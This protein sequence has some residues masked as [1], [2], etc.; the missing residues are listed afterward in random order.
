MATAPLERR[1]RNVIL[2]VGDGMGISTVTA[3]RILDGQR[4]GTTG[5][6]NLLAF[7]RL[8]YVALSRTYSIDGQVPDSASTMTA[9]ITG[10]KNNDGV[11]SLDARVALGDFR[12]APGRE[13][14]TLVERAEARGLATGIVTTA[15]LTHATPAACYAHA[16][17]RDWESDADLPE[18]A[19]AAG[20]KDIARQFVEFAHG[21]GIDVALGGGRAKFL[22]AGAADPEDTGKSGGRGDGRDL[23]AAWRARHPE[24]VFVWNKAQFDAVDPARTR[25]LLG[26]FER[27]HMEFEHDRAQDAGGEPSL[28]EMTA[29][30]IDILARNRKGYVLVV[31]GGRIDHAHH[32]GNAYRALT[33]TIALADAVAAALGKVDLRD[34]LVVVTADHSHVFTIGGY[35]KRG[36]AILGKV[37]EIGA[38]G[39][40]RDAQGLPYTTLLYANGPGYR[41]SR[42]PDLTAVDTADPD[43]LQEAAV[44]LE[45]ET[46]AGEDVAVYAGGPMAHLVRGVLEQNAIYHVMAYALGLDE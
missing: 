14:A 42:R 41:G 15:R 29:K 24:G 30:A 20:V 44:P 23:V 8:P 45:S 13:L 10:A 12:A 18:A 3:A 17:H 1:A 9:L 38:P 43:Y 11:L 22:P 7:E 28:A 37:V 34:T 19:R 5:E 4:R 32:A 27:S 33:D 35:P 26:L 39:Y 16:A 40:A 25:R 6:E 2:F 46:H 21:D 36:N 31:E